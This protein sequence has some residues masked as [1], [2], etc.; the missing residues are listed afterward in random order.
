MSGDGAGVR[1]PLAEIE[2]LIAEIERLA[3][4]AAR[5]R[6][7]ALVAAVLDL[8]GAALARV[9]A[10]AGGS[11]AGPGLLEAL[12]ADDLV[13]PLLILHGVHPVPLAARVATVV[14]RLRAAGTDVD[15]VTIEG[16]TVRLRL[17]REGGVPAR[18]RRAAVETAVLEAAPDAETIEI[19]EGLAV[20]LVPWGRRPPS[21]A[22]TEPAR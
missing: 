19:D 11:A 21:P 17:G 22:G 1:Q 5:G 18:A 20:A 6:A 16:G 10:I 7:R 13:A 14:E 15:V 8:H 12:A 4:P 9:L 3:D 2:S